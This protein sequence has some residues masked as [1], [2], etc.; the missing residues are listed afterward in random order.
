M[1]NSNT[2]TSI[3]VCMGL[4]MSMMSINKCIETVIT[5]ISDINPKTNQNTNEYNL[6]KQSKSSIR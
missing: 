6:K 4:N 1:I 2:I 5:I 3:M